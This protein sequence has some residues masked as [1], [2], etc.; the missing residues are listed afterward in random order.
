MRYLLFLFLAVLTGNSLRAA[1]RNL[2][3]VDHACPITFLY[4]ADWKVVPSPLDVIGHGHRCGLLVEPTHLKKRLAE[5][6]MDVFSLSVSLTVD[7]VSFQKGLPDSRFMQEANG[8]W[9]ILGRLD[10]KSPAH[11][12]TGPGWS[13]VQGVATA[14]CFTEH[15]GYQGLCDSPQ[16]FLGNGKRSVLI[17]AGLDLEEQ[18]E[19]ILRTFR[20][21][22]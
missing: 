14:G 17:E 8:V 9:V 20:F 7:D 6:D 13:G 1:D 3:Y 4:P 22:P 15:G 10:I 16:A 11:R 5:T 12:I 2:R 21:R 19:T 18:F